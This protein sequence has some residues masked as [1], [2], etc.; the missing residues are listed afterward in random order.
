MKKYIGK[1]TY[2]NLHWEVKTRGYSFDLKKKI[3]PPAPT[4]KKVVEDNKTI[5]FFCGGGPYPP[6]QSCRNDIGGLSSERE[7]NQI[8]PVWINFLLGID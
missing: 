8:F 4:Q 3:R 5:I 2:L 7:P 6:K 1:K